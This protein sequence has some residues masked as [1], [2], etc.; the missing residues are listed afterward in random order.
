MMSEMNGLGYNLQMLSGHSEALKAYQGAIGKT[1]K[2]MQVDDSYNDG[3]GGLFIHFSDGT[4]I[5]F[6]DD[7]RS[8]CEL[9][10]LH[11]DDDLTSFA[12]A[13]FTG[14]ELRDGGNE[15]D[16]ETDGVHEW[17][18]VYVN[19]SKGVATLETHNQHNGYYGGIFLNV[20]QVEAE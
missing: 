12:G 20:K 13:T 7:A 15:G 9:R 19:T 16:D 14:I 10:Y 1:I 3:D 2:T 17:M 11:T 8:C 5:V 6:Y 18:F 4:A